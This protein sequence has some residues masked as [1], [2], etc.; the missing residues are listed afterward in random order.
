MAKSTAISEKENSNSLMSQIISSFSQKLQPL[1]DIAWVFLLQ[2]NT[3]LAAFLP[4]WL[5]PRPYRPY[6]QVYRSLPAI[7]TFSEPVLFTNLPP[8]KISF[9]VWRPN[10]QWKRKTPGRPD[11]HVCVVDGRSQF[12]SLGHLEELYNSVAEKHSLGARNGKVVIAVVDNGVSNY[13]TLDEHLNLHEI[14]NSED[15]L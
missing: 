13:M 14:D 5:F 9:E 3:L 11:F 1:Y 10:P 12:P 15:T 4:L 7:A 8:L 2:L 6:D